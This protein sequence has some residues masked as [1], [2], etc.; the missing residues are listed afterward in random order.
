[1]ARVTR[2][3]A[4]HD[5]HLAKVCLNFGTVCISTMLYQRDSYELHCMVILAAIWV[6]CISDKDHTGRPQYFI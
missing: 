2:T 4:R 5:K 1:M 3:H 6:Y